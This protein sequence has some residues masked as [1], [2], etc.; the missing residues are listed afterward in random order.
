MSYSQGANFHLRQTIIQFL[1][2]IMKLDREFT[3][4]ILN[5]LDLNR[6]LAVNLFQC[7]ASGMQLVVDFLQNFSRDFDFCNSLYQILLDYIDLVPEKLMNH[8]GK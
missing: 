7:D 5:D 2:R 1:N 6:F 3:P 4:V 8:N